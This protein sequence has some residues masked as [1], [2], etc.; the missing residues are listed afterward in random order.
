MSD[1]RVW[2]QLLTRTLVVGLNIAAVWPGRGA[3]QIPAECQVSGDPAGKG[4]VLDSRQAAVRTQPGSWLPVCCETS[5][6]LT[7][8]PPPPP[9]RS[10]EVGAT[11]SNTT[12]VLFVSW[13]EEEFLE[14]HAADRKVCLWS[15]ERFS[16]SSAARCRTASEGRR[17]GTP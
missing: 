3:R 11:F 5:G 7:E 14:R 8:P 4:C 2:L 10:S 9:P 6:P 17:S 16:V 12:V 15:A 1:R 13:K